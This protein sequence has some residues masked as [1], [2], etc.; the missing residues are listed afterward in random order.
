MIGNQVLGRRVLLAAP[1]LAAIPDLARAATTGTGAGAGAPVCIVLNSGGATLSIIDMAT[2][3]V[4]REEPAFREPSHWALSPDR[5]RLLIADASGNALFFLDPATGKELGHKLIP[6]P[7]QLWFSPD[8]KFLTVNCLR[9]NRVDIYH[10]DTLKL[11][12]R[13]RVGSMPS[14]LS[15]TPDSRTVFCSM[16]DSG[17]LVAIDLATMTPRW[18][19]KVGKTPAGVFWHDG[20]VLVGI[21][22]SN[23]VAVVDPASGRVIRR[24]V[25]DKGAHTQ[26]LTP[27]RKQIYVTNRVAGSLSVLDAKSLAVMKRIPMPGGPDDL[28]FA[29]DGKLWISLRFSSRVGVFDPATG[30]IERISVG[31]SPHGIFISTLLTDAPARAAM[32]LA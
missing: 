9:L 32:R 12:K 27:D 26:F 24:I 14:H 7:Y 30:A 16:Q 29:P 2:R 10:A 6:D 20:V 28:C 23:N 4:L 15:Y 8:G 19:A 18:H 11:A 13:F 25:T 21:M 31:R 1:A 3:R 17:T 22:G 5:K